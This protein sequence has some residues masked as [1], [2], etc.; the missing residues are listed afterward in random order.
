ML[1]ITIQLAIV[2]AVLALSSWWIW[3]NNDREQQRA[4]IG[5]NS[6]TYPVAY[7]GSMLTAS[8]DPYVEAGSEVFI[9]TGDGLYATRVKSKRGTRYR[10]YLACWLEEKQ[11][12]I[13]IIITRSDPSCRAEWLALKK[14]HPE[15]LNVYMLDRNKVSGDRAAR[16]KSRIDALDTFHPV[17]LITPPGSKAHPGAMWIEANHPIG[18][19]FAYGVE[20][21]KPSDVKKD[22]RFQQYKEMYDDLLVGTHVTILTLDEEHGA[23]ELAAAA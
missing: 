14:K 7:T 15:R 5:L 21:L 13:N 17:L 1:A 10:D 23:H 4:L 6:A 20:F 8:F 18:S 19:K 12:T 16:L 9:P 11:T 3:T 22:P 2:V